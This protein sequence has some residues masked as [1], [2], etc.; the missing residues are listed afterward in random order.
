MSKLVT[1]W[2]TDIELKGTAGKNNIPVHFKRGLFQRDTFS[3]LL[4]CLSIAPL[5]H[6]LS[7]AGGFRSEFHNERITHQVYIDDVKL[8]EGNKEEL[9]A[10]MQMTES[11][12]EVIGM[13][14][15]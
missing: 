12:L 5:S 7:L 3:P 8:Y 9:E 14:R 10:T 6:S 4:F 2:V 15:A 1:L 13:S 11:V